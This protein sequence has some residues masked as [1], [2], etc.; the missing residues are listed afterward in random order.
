MHGFTRGALRAPSLHCS[1]SRA[2]IFSFGK[3]FHQ[4]KSPQ[5]E[6]SASYKKELPDSSDPHLFLVSFLFHGTSLLYLQSLPSTVHLFCVPLRR[7]FWS[8]FLESSFLAALLEAFYYSF[9]RLITMASQEMASQ[10]HQG[11]GLKWPP[12]RPLLIHRRGLIIA[13]LLFFILFL[14]CFIRV[15][16]IETAKLERRAL[17]GRQFQL[18]GYLGGMFR[19]AVDTSATRTSPA[20]H[21]T[22]QD[23]AASLS[24]SIRVTEAAT[25]L[26]SMPEPTGMSESKASLSNANSLLETLADA[27]KEAFMESGQ[28]SASAAKHRQKNVLSNM[29]GGQ[30]NA[31]A[32]SEAS[33][34][35]PIFQTSRSSS[36]Q[37]LPTPAVGSLGGF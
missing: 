16:I 9:N 13:S 12:R 34:L 18:G 33:S 6:S 24:V 20:A 1:F 8:F 2:S 22:N 10:Q 28:P 4:T 19:E 27:V 25:A 17:T 29:I 37:N 11:S 31:L 21:T 3:C 32:L 26:S 14:I 30:S 15:A 36:T 23:S 35:P 7:Q 5:I